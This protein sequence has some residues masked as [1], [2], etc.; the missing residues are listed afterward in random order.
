[1]GFCRCIRSWRL[2]G[3][4]ARC[5]HL[6]R[7]KARFTRKSNS[8]HSCSAPCSRRVLALREARSAKCEG[9]SKRFAMPPKLSCR[10][11]SAGRFSFGL[12]IEQNSDLHKNRCR[13]LFGRQQRG[14]F[15]APKFGTFAIGA[16]LFLFGQ[17]LSR[18]CFLGCLQGF[19]AFTAAAFQIFYR[20]RTPVPWGHSCADGHGPARPPCCTYAPP[21]R[22]N[23]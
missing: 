20:L 10:A 16:V 14:L 11:T 18:L 3:I 12:A 17:P 22:W 23:G 4:S 19:H 13:R 5:C 15:R 21:V 6:S 9:F 2:V 1:M 7:C 8:R